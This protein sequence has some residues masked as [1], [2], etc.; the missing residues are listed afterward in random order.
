MLA[1]LGYW[2]TVT[3]LNAVTVHGTRTRAWSVSYKPSRS[4]ARTLEDDEYVYKPI[5]AV[6]NLGRRST[7]VYNVEVAEDHSYVSDF[8][9]HNCELYEAVPHQFD[10]ERDGG[11]F[12]IK[13]AD[14]QP[15]QYRYH[16]LTVWAM[17]DMGWRNLCALHARSWS[18]A[19]HPT[20]R[21]KPLVDRASL[22][23]HSEGL[24]VGLGCLASRT[25]AALATQGEE[26]AYQQAKWAAEVF[27]GRCFMEVMGN[28]PEQQALIRGQRRVAQR[29]GI[30]VIATNDVH[31]TLQEHGREH[32]PHHTLV[33]SRMFKKAGTEASTDRSDTGFGSWHGSGFWLK[34]GAEML[35]TG[36]LLRDEI[37]RTVEVLAMADF[38]FN[39]IP[40]PA[41]PVA[42]VLIPSVGD[43]PAFD[44][45]VAAHT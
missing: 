45:F 15:G 9:L 18:P 12:K 34:S 26:A 16:H 33:Q 44:A 14:L 27:A 11:I 19:Y 10:M 41:P 42:D 13:W 22:E 17:N 40:K 25:S 29:L 30:P 31:Y 36:G 21:G 43:D 32:G 38:D 8:I 24:I 4:H 2:T 23:E 35:A 6:R 39:A 1:D 28:L 37:T 7:T 3:E 20:V 5:R